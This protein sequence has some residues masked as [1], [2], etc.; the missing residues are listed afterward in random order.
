MIGAMFKAAKIS[1]RRL[2]A[3]AALCAAACGAARAQDFSIKVESL[4]CEGRSDPQAVDTE[5]PM[6][7]WLILAEGNPGPPRGV[8]Q[9]AWQ[10]LAARSPDALARNEGNLWDSGR[11]ESGDS[12]QVPYA[13]TPPPHSGDCWWK[14]RV[15]ARDAA[16]RET[17]SPWSRP[18]FWRR[19]PS[20]ELKTRGWIQPPPA[21]AGADS[22]PAW[23]VRREFVIEKEI[24]RAVVY[25]SS[26]GFCELFINGERIGDGI[27]LPAAADAAFRIYHLSHEVSR[28]V[29]PGKNTIGLALGPGWLPDGKT[30]SAWLVLLAGH[31]DG[32]ATLITPDKSWKGAYTPSLAWRGHAMSGGAPETAW[33]RPGFDDSAWSGVS[34][35][36][37]PRG[38]LAAQVIPPARASGEEAAVSAAETSPGQWRFDFGRV[39][40]GRPRVTG[41]GFSA[42][43]V[44]IIP[45]LGGSPAPGCE[46]GWIARG[47]A[48][49]GFE[50]RFA[51]A[52]FDAV[53]ARGLAPG[54]AAAV[55]VKISD[56]IRTSSSF[57]CS[58]PDYEAAFHARRNALAAGCFGFPSDLGD[59]PAPRG[60]LAGRAGLIAGDLLMF[61]CAP[62]VK[63]WLADLLDAQ[64]PDGSLP[65]WAP[66]LGN[67]SEADWRGS[68]AVV[69]VPLA[70]HAITGDRRP[71][72]SSAPAIEAFLRKHEAAVASAE[73]TGQPG[74][75][76]ALALAE[77]ALRLARAGESAG[78]APEEAGSEGPAADLFDNVLGAAPG[79]SHIMR[80]GGIR[81][82]PLRPGFKRAIIRPEFSGGMEWANAG[83]LSPHGWF[84]C[85]WAKQRGGGETIRIR[86]E[87]PP[88][89]SASVRLPCPPE[90]VSESGGPVAEAP[91]IQAA[92][93]EDAGTV[94]LA[95]SGTYEFA[96]LL[97]PPAAP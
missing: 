78:A 87:I 33:A 58:D 83:F 46:Q 52:R 32:S 49:T 25:Y 61:D 97:P 20:H 66:P 63:K 85:S 15:W 50:P 23:A 35:V 19:G 38:I 26:T 82:D 54:P 3:A 79:A 9:T 93:R 22:L 18:A 57:T 77:L 30:P 96:A 65:E 31:P 34:E 43:G 91:G 16:G 40:Q 90:N 12:I 51:I 7:S 62:L 42:P 64:R 68:F 47:E 13:G 14:V 53:E 69:T 80:A 60:R 27:G 5:R 36:A 44:S 81:P 67:P 17:L 11:V 86:V 41:S 10:I 72:E 75:R 2:L 37:A 6:L 89:A 88:N 74:G 73:N 71:L 21:P 84:R 76:A 55:A 28:R 45:L 95:G 94:L 8:V 29:A 48:E 92:A 4:R 39:L 59:G 70:L 24:S 1:A 56:D